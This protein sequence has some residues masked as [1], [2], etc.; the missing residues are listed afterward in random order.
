[1]G[2][3]KAR[4]GNQ[5]PK[6][7][8]EVEIDLKFFDLAW[9][10]NVFLA[11]CTC[12]QV[13]ASGTASS[14]GAAEATSTP[15]SFAF[16]IARHLLWR[17]H[18]GTSWSIAMYENFKTDFNT[19]IIAPSLALGAALSL[20]NL[21]NQNLLPANQP[22]TRKCQ[23][24]LFPQHLLASHTFHRI[25]SFSRS[26]IH[27]GPIIQRPRLRNAAAVT[28]EAVGRTWVEIEQPQK[29]WKSWRHW[30]NNANLWPTKSNFYNF[31]TRKCWKSS[32][33]LACCTCYQVT[34]SGTASSP[35]AAEATSTPHSFAFRIAWH[36]L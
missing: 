24:S 21:Q 26:I 28:W 3:C 30:C 16:R 25:C 22:N 20:R 7:F 15:H 8:T 17:S 18:S 36:V 14:P 27:L 35:G 31:S 33:K 4:E 11:C 1:M 32:L 10:Q 6:T 13:T 23:A 12:Y 19:K 2:K 5:W 29:V 34:A 9:I